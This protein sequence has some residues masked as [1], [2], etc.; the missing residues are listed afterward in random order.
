MVVEV[1]PAAALY[2][3]GLPHRKYKGPQHRHTRQTIVAGLQRVFPTLNWN[4]FEACLI[5]ND[6]ALDAV[7]AG[8]ITHQ[9]VAGLCYGLTPYQRSTAR[10]EGWIWLP[11]VLNG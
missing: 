7:V 1:Y 4:G 5:G 10:I 2:C 9:T 3:W 8:L 6:N 11:Q